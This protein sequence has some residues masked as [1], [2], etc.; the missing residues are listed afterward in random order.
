MYALNPRFW[1]RGY[2]KEMVRGFLEGPKS[3]AE[4]AGV[5]AC[6]IPGN[7]GSQKVLKDA[8]LM[9]TDENLRY[10]KEGDLYYLL[11][12]RARTNAE[13]WVFC[14]VYPSNIKKLL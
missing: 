14:N 9:T 11:E 5:A 2:A 10:S 12:R 6:V 3:M 8:G 4:L 13:R 7:G 1:G